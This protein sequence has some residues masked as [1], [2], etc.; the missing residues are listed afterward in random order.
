MIPN[1]PAP[2]P[3]APTSD[4]ADHDWRL[5]LLD[6]LRDGVVVLDPG[7]R[8]EYVNAAAA[9]LLER[10]RELMLGRLV[11]ELFPGARDGAA[12]AG[13][14]R[15]LAER[16]AVTLD[17]RLSAAERWVRAT[18]Y[19]LADR[20]GVHFRDV[21]AGKVADAAGEGALALE[22]QARE[23]A[24]AAFRSMEAAN[25]AK[26]E[27]LAVMSH[28]LRTPLT[29][30]QGYAQLL[31]LGVHG[32]VSEQQRNTL[33]RIQAALREQL[34]TLRPDLKLPF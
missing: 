21:T 10:P 17:T 9:A 7:W 14:R 33:A 20:L 22:H 1:P 5:L 16:R 18:Y 30:I 32:P 12:H 8:Y 34:I 25:L 27:F 2:P 28:E 13:A 4:A 15:A 26:T 24:E 11:W 6:D 29:A 23:A 31:E 3:A 19:P